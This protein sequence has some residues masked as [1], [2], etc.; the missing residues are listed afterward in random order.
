MDEYWNNFLNWLNNIV[1][2]PIRIAPRVQDRYANSYR[3]YSDDDVFDPT[4]PG[5]KRSVLTKKQPWWRQGFIMQNINDGDT[6]YTERPNQKMG[7]NRNRI[8]KASSKD[9]DRREYEILR[10]R[11][12]DAWRIANDVR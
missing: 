3:A 6:T 11:F 1:N 7:F 10:R 4:I 2:P 5:E 8:R 12:N 9:K